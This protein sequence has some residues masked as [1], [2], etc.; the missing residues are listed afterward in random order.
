MQIVVIYGFHG[1]YSGE[2]EYEYRNP[3]VGALHKCMLFL[4]QAND[5]PSEES[6]L[7]ECAKYGFM[8][9]QFSGYG[10]L[11]VETLNKDQFRGFAGFYEEALRE[12]S[13]LVYYPN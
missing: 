11:E 3:E 2:T 9:V 10:P 12:G 1:K 13:S 8:D 6:A 5:A 7:A 4:S